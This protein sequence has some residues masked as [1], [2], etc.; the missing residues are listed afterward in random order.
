MSE[1]GKLGAKL[2]VIALAAGLALGVTNAVT[3]EP[4]ALEQIAA[5]ETAR[6]TVL[7]SAAAFE[8]AS[9]DGAETAFVAKDA[10]GKVVGATGTLTVTG[11]GGPIEITVGLDTAGVITGV[12]VGGAGFAETAGLGAKTKDAAFTSQF[13]GKDATVALKKN[14]GDIDA[15]TSATIS[16]GA[17]TNGVAAL[18][19][20]IAPLAKEGK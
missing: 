17:V 18:T 15:V 9:A 5:A 4:I 19:K 10:S 2:L 16:S 8:P 1:M 11:F 20:A 3:K 13:N 14:G 7:P 12:S 6:K